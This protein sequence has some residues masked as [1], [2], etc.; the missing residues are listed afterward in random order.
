M[1]VASPSRAAQTTS[2]TGGFDLLLVVDMCCVAAEN[3]Q[4]VC[5]LKLFFIINGHRN[6][7]RNNKANSCKNN[8][9]KQKEEK[10]AGSKKKC[11]YIVDSSQQPNNSHQRNHI[12]DDGE[13][14]GLF[15]AK[16]INKRERKA[17]RNNEK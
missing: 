8:P 3:A 1:P 4:S 15:D 13:K 5:I 12:S 2:L 9:G 17:I 14:A 6:K 10:C 11:L 7:I 16:L